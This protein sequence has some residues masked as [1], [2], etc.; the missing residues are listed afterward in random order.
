MY[1]NYVFIID[2][3]VCCWFFFYNIF[4]IQPKYVTDAKAELK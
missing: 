1:I 3:P 4:N 2:I